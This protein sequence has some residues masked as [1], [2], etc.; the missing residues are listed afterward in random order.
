MIIYPS[1]VVSPSVIPGPVGVAHGALAALI[2]GRFAQSG[3]SPLIRLCEPLSDC[4]PLR[5]SDHPSDLLISEIP[6]RLLLLLFFFSS[7]VDRSAWGVSKWY[8]FL[9]LIIVYSL[10][11]WPSSGD[12][13]QS[14]LPNPPEQYMVR[15]K[16][17]P[18][19]VPLRPKKCQ[20][21]HRPDPERDLTWYYFIAV[22]L[23]FI[24]MLF[25]FRIAS[26]RRARF[27]HTH[28]LRQFQA[29][30]IDDPR[31]YHFSHRI[32]SACR[33]AWVS[34][35]SGR[36]CRDGALAT[37]STSRTS[38]GFFGKIEGPG[39]PKSPC[40]YLSDRRRIKR[41]ISRWP[42]RPVVAHASQGRFPR[43]PDVCQS[44]VY[45]REESHIGRD[46]LRRDHI[47]YLSESQI[48][49]RALDIHQRALDIRSFPYPSIPR[50]SRCF[51]CISARRR[52]AFLKRRIF[53]IFLRRR[54]ESWIIST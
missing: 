27:R 42:R 26:R 10:R 3:R 35:A 19:S 23:P 12:W 30:A 47:N 48:Y 49:P 40:P 16:C 36:A 44:D 13:G 32:T 51:L 17:L 41:R 8:V 34:K 33:F 21:L 22:P 46:V 54:Q 5:A 50:L 7:S 37:W 11:G 2:Y 43:L 1:S 25:C 45:A 9:Y 53:H 52:A 28:P 39:I 29:R 18:Y 20:S 24:P 14:V 31:H 6:G 4:Q 15:L 38:G